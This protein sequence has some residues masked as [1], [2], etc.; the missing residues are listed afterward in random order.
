MSSLSS[1]LS[2]FPSYQP[3]Q[4]QQ[5][6]SSYL[7]FGGTSHP[8]LTQGICEKLGVTVGKCEFRYFANSEQKPIIDE[9]VRGKDIFIV[10]TGSCDPSYVQYNKDGSSTTMSKSVGDHVTETL[11]LMDACTRSGCKSISLIIPC[12][13]YARQDKKDK[14][15]APISAKLVAKQFE[16]FKKFE[17]ITCVELH[18]P[19]IQGYFDVSCDNLYTSELMVSTL[20]TIYEESLRNMVIISPDE[21]GAKR[22][23]VVADKLRL[24]LLTMRKKRDYSTENKIEETK[25]M[26]EP[27]E[28]LLLKN[29]VAIIV[30][31]MLDTGGTIIESVNVLRKAGAKSVIVI[32]THGILSGKAIERINN[33]PY[34]ERVIVSNSLPQTKHRKECPKLYVY[35]LDDLLSNVIERLVNGRSVSELF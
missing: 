27:D 9:T 4:H 10:Q 8:E 34:L 32:V 13:P 19:C 7:V 14:P 5:Q 31:D 6:Q 29:R 33:E 12:Y 18:N 28:L 2:S 11:L 21:G 30:D 25:V 3:Q 20:K 23:G 35:K 1:S 17:R 26:G 22:A 16:I 15:R 24:P